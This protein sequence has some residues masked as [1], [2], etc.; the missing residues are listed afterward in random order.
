MSIQKA[1]EL[2]NEIENKRNNWD[3]RS[4]FVIKG[5]R[6]LSSADLDVIEMYADN[7]IQSGGFSF[8]GLM[9]PMGEVRE[10]LEAYKLKSM[11]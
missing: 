5:V 11:W 2:K 9:N 3:E 7:Y 8:N 10:V 4:Q 1:N 6:N